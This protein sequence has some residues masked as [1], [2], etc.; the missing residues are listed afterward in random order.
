MIKDK[1]AFFAAVAKPETA[2]VEIPGAGVI[3]V[4]ALNVAELI[5]F[6][7]GLKVKSDVDKAVA[8]IV[9][10]AVDESGE[11]FFAADDADRLQSSLSPKALTILTDAAAKLNALG[12][13]DADALE[14]N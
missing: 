13:D 11:P 4:K 3:R 1:K 5:A 14:K 6:E 2:E 12:K 8:L 9:A 7:D 10:T